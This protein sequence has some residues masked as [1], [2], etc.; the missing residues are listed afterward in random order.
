MVLFTSIVFLVLYACLIFYYSKGWKSTPEFTPS[1]TTDPLFISVIV[2]A[3]NEE[4]SIGRL[5]EAMAAQTY[6]AQ[7]FELI[8]VDDYSTD[9]TSEIITSSSIKNLKLTKPQVD[10]HESSKK[11]A[12]ESGVREASGELIV[13][14]DADCVPGPR[15]LETISAFYKARGASFIAAPVRYTQDGSIL[16][17]YQA[18]DFLTLQGITAAS[19]TLAFHNMCNGA[20]LAYEKK[21][22]SSVNGFEGIDRVATG[23][24]LLLM[25][26]IWKQ[27][28][29]KVFF[30]KSKEAIVN[31][32]PMPSWKALMMQRK[33][34]ASKS[35]VYKDYRIIAVLVFVYLLNCL[36]VVLVALSFFHS[37]YW[38]M[39]AG[40]WIVKTIIELPFVSSVAKFY[41]E[42][43]SLRYFFFFQPLHMFFTA[44]TG[45]VSQ[46]GKYEWK[47]RKTK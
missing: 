20:N 44:L 31:T 2:A 12:I 8:I 3:R 40:F 23:D 30:L 27:D 28:P 25:H 35:F 6:E 22:F 36:F 26:K 43:R 10:I 13:T 38:W 47:G 15:W 4:K 16:Q 7:Y 1:I 46:A 33:R 21:A 14:T 19:V 37:F 9:H 17:T 42:Q 32:E 24:D 41:G 11:K 45:L 34:W 39:V 5:L 29:S 18:L